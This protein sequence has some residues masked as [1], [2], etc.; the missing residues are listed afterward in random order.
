MAV[1]G[2]GAFSYERGTPALPTQPPCMRPDL[3][4]FW[5]GN[6][7]GTSRIRNSAPLGSYISRNMFGA[8]WRP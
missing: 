1:L 5:L 4:G 3:F 8:L 6:Y 7:S 2:G